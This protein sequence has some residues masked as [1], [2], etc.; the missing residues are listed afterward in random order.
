MITQKSGLM[1]YIP[2]SHTSGVALR[3]KSVPDG[4]VTKNFTVITRSGG[5]AHRERNGGQCPQYL[6]CGF[7]LAWPFKAI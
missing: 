6:L 1:K 4:F 2:V 7:N 3:A 5:I